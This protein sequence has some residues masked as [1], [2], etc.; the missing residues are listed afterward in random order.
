M[1]II[2]DFLFVAY[3]LLSSSILKAHEVNKAGQDIQPDNLFPR[4]KLETAVGAVVVELD[5]IKAPITTNNFLAYAAKGTYNNTIFHRVVAEFVV[6]GGGY[7]MFYG[8]REQLA[9]IYNESGN[10]LKNE[11][12]TIAMAREDEPHSATSQFYFN[13][14]D[15]PGLDPGKGWG[16]TVF[17]VVIEGTEILDAIS[18]ANTHVHPELGWEDVPVKEILLKKVTILP[19]Q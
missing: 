1:K 9:P 18:K 15:N 11:L 13:M 12:Y 19:E 7:D 17:G 16:Y 5:R 14:G 6:Q 3:V 10:G 4:V 2:R 8:E